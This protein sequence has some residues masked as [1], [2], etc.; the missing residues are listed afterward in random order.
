MLMKNRKSNSYY[1]T[2]KRTDKNFQRSVPVHFLY[3][4]KL[5]TRRNRL[6]WALSMRFC[7]RLSA[8]PRYLDSA[9]EIVEQI[10]DFIQTVSLNAVRPSY[11]ERVADCYKI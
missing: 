2:D 6:Y 5:W 8:P 11:A 3:V 7:K 9:Q 10:D 1:D 4:S